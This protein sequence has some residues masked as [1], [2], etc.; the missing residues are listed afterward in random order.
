MGKVAV[1]FDTNACHSKRE[2]QVFFGDRAT[3][4]EIASRAD[5]LIPQIVIDELIQ[6][7]S[8]GTEQSADNLRKN[9]LLDVLGFDRSKVDSL[10]SVIH[11]KEIYDKENIQHTVVQISDT[12]RAF[13]NLQRWSVVGSPPF[14]ARNKDGKN[15]SDKGI[16]D[17]LVA[18]TV[19][20][21][22]GKNDYETYYLACIDSR[23]K[24]YYRDN[25]RISCLSP[26]EILDE[27]KKEFFDEYTLDKTK[28]EL[29][30]PAIA[31]VGDWININSDIVGLFSY[32][33]YRT[34][35]IFDKNSKEILESTDYLF[36][37]DSNLLNT[38]GSFAATHDAVARISGSVA[39]YSYDDIQKIRKGLTT[40][41]QVYG[42][43]TDDDVKG[44][45]KQIFDYISY[46]LSQEEM[47]I[48]EDYYNIRNEP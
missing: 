12:E 16:K 48:F 37:E 38:S 9:P 34:I 23:L 6:Q 4:Q 33:E 19:D 28:K 35:V 20:E 24:E 39:Y 27:L 42:I 7:N 43:G 41:D 22:L 2:T 3:M 45:A 1:I 11:A 47:Q 15:N 29:D 46:D 31:L 36:V 32:E 44:L 17:A 30:W 26:S 21:I 8:E 18:C 14:N 5:I 25:K 10:D 40:N 13:Q